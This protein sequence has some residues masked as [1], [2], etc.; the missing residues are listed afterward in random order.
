[1]FIIVFRSLCVHYC[2]HVTL[3]SLLCSDHFVFIIV[4]RSLCVCHCVQVTVCSLLCSCHFVFI[5]LCVYYCV[6]VTVCSLLC[7]G[8]FVFM[9]GTGAAAGAEFRLLTTDLRQ[10]AEPPY[11][12]SFWYHAYS[13]TPDTGTLEV[14]G[15][16]GA[17]L[18]EPLWSQPA[19]A[20]N[21]GESISVNC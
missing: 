11:M 19:L 20:A 18:P 10:F 4:F 13:T 9:D 14:R 3:C 17:V 12:V 16:N 5:S 8:H 2:D 1:M 6:Y 7:S 15:W 21:I